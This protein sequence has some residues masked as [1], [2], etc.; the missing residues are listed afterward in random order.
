MQ[1]EQSLKIEL[2]S[3]QYKVK[4][5][6]WNYH[7]KF[8]QKNRFR[9]LFDRAFGLALNENMQNGIGHRN[10]LKEF[11][12]QT[13]DSWLLGSKL[14]K[15]S[16]LSAFTH[17]DFI[18]GVT[19]SLDDLHICYGQSLV[20]MENEYAYHRRLKPDFSLKKLKDLKTGDVLVFGAPFSYYGDLHPQTIEILNKCLNLNIPVHIDAAWFGCMR[21]FNFN[22]DHPAIATVS[23]SLS[24]GLGLGSNRVG[25]RYSRLRHNGPVSIV[26]DYSMEINSVMSCGIHFMEKFGSDYLQNRYAEAYKIVCEKLQLKPTKAIHVA[27][28]EDEISGNWIPMGIRPFLRYLVDNLNEFS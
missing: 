19:H 17:R 21:D 12:F 16:G 1:N 20:A 3:L 25:V 11:F 26:N 2:S 24:K 14:N 23:F 4:N 15:I 5:L 9:P 27:F 7:R 13:F 6:D 22:F 18:A 8:L 28:G 10:G